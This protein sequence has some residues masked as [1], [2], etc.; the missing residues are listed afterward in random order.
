MPPLDIIKS[1][2]EPRDIVDIWRKYAFRGVIWPASWREFKPTAK[3]NWKF[4]K[5][6]DASKK[7]VPKKRGIYAFVIN[8]ESP[9]FPGHG[10]IAYVGI[11]GF[12]RNSKRNFRDRFTE[13]IRAKKIGEKRPKVDELLQN[14]GD[15]LMFWYAPVPDQRIGLKKLERSIN[16][17]IVPPMVENDFSAEIKRKVKIFRSN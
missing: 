1:D 14:W 17:V 11:T 4:V 10:Y 6:S 7:K 3:L 12:V 15:D 9:N 13:Y 8:I 2:P 5:F 16:D